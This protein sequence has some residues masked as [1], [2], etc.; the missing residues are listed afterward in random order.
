MPFVLKHRASSELFACGLVNRYELPYYGVKDWDD[1]AA[2][3][4]ERESFLAAREVGD[5][6]DWDVVELEEMKLKMANVKLRNDP[7]NRLFLDDGGAFRVVR[8]E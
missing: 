2:A 3:L 6:A 5:P 1:E 8:R 7:A 4:G